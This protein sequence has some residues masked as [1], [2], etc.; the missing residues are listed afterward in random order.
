MHEGVREAVG[1]VCR[2]VLLGLSGVVVLV[3]AGAS[4]TAAASVAVDLRA[5]VTV[6]DE[7]HRLGSLGR[8]RLGGRVKPDRYRGKSYITVHTPGSAGPRHAWISGG[9]LIAHPSAPGTGLHRVH[10]TGLPYGPFTF[11]DDEALLL[12]VA[13]DARVFVVDARLPAALSEPGRK[14]LR[15]ALAELRPSGHVAFLTLGAEAEFAAARALVRGLAPEAPLLGD[16]RTPVRPVALRRL[17]QALR[18]IGLAKVTLITADAELAAA[19]A[20][21][22]G[23]MPATHFIG[24]AD[25]RFAGLDKLARYDSV[26]QW[27]RRL[28][29]GG[30][31][32]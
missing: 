31:P 29:G 7:I 19:A 13:Q 24:P 9:V 10:C 30:G 25:V 11:Y 20:G 1:F 26:A 2:W 18:H 6:P 28:V 5:S 4:V 14:E 17:R 3:A 8:Y 21:R 27:R 23:A 32:R 16:L 12:V 22:G 15:A